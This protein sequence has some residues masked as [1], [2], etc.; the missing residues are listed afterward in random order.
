VTILGKFGWVTVAVWMVCAGPL[1]AQEAPLPRP[2][3]PGPEDVF[4]PEGPPSSDGYL[5]PPPNGGTAG[6][7]V[8]N[9]GYAGGDS[10][11]DRVNYIREAPTY[12]EPQGCIG[13]GCRDSDFTPLASTTQGVA[14]MHR[15]QPRSHD[16]SNIVFGT[17]TFI[18]YD[19]TRDVLVKQVFSASDLRF[20]MAPG[21]D[22]VVERYLG[23]DANNYDWYLQGGFRG[24]NDWVA[25]ATATAITID[26][27]TH[28]PTGTRQIDAHYGS[29]FNSAE[30]NMVLR[31]HPRSDRIV[32]YPNGEWHREVQPATYWSFLAGVRYFNVDECIALMGTEGG[33]EVGTYAART[34]N[35]LIGLNFG[36]DVTWRDRGWDVGFHFKVS[37]MLNTAVADTRVNGV[38]RWRYVDTNLAAILEVGVL[39]TYRLSEAWAVR[40]GYDISWLTGGA[41]APLQR[42]LAKE[43]DSSGTV[44]FQGLT[45]GMEYRQ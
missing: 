33:V 21:Y 37:P 38:P 43:V 7:I 32:L 29:E 24:F 1:A 44:F 15:G 22:E 36:T 14:L 10:Q 35:D 2:G 28:L 4:R 17:P 45:I 6:T 8:P 40:A 23:R 25:T 19:A 11:W 3:V 5:S 12:E 39:T 16:L 20:Q 13:G 31:P 41:F 34:Q 42:P 27:I 9:S 18:R 26:P 30:I